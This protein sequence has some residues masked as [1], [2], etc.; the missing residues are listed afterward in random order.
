MPQLDQFTY[1]TQF[2]WLFVCFM[3]FYVLLYNNGLP[4]VSRILKLRNL[5]VNKTAAVTETSTATAVVRPKLQLELQS[6]NESKSSN[7]SQVGT[8]NAVGA[9]IVIKDSL[10]GCISFLNSSLSSASEWCAQMV[11]HL[12]TSSNLNYDTSIPPT[13]VNHCYLKSVGE[14]SLAQMIKHITLSRCTPLS[15]SNVRFPVAEK[16][17]A[18]VELKVQPAVGVNR[19][20]LLRMQHKIFNRQGVT[21]IVSHNQ[22]P[23]QK[24][25]RSQNA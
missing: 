15:S 9:D 21:H 20:Y 17:T 12:N 25:K 1:F 24:K 13:Q 11:T 14:I 16:K 5:L 23:V 7:T 10:N 22:K 2:I 4:K 8:A 18:A 19:I 3:S 6:N